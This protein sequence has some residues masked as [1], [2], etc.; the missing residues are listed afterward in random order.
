MMPDGNEAG[1]RCALTIFRQVSPH[2][3]VRW[4]KLANGKQPTDLSREQLKTSFT[5]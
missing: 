3:F 2:R 4:V 5:M 1:E